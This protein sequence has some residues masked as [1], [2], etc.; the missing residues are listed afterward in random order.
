MEA[1]QNFTKHDLYAKAYGTILKSYIDNPEQDLESLARKLIVYGV[2]MVNSKNEREYITQEE[3]E[4]DFQFATNIKTFMGLLTPTEFME[5]FPISKEIRGHKYGF[6][7]YFYTRDYLKDL[8]PEPIGGGKAVTKFLWEYCNWEIDEF[9]ANLMGYLSN[10]R[11][12]A[13]QTSMLEEWGKIM[14]VKT[15]TIHTDHKGTQFMQEH[16]TGKITKLRKA[17]PRYLKLVR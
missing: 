16:G 14:G 2:K 7:D 17:R 5:L 15:Y 11:K 13:G 9:N 1:A 12:L 4:L 3:A 10:L 6:K 8:D